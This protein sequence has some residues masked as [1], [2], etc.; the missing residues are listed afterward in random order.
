VTDPATELP[1]RH[2]FGPAKQLYQPFIYSA[3]QIAQL[4]AAARRLM[5]RT[6]HRLTR[7]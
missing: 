1:P 3:K 5:G 4:L 6:G 7:H 2:L